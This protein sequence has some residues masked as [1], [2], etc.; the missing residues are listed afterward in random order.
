M[1]CIGMHQFVFVFLC[2]V[3]F[4]DIVC[5]YYYYHYNRF[6]ALW[7]LSGTAR[8]S[9]YKKGKTNLHLLEQEIVSGSGI[10]WTMCTAPH[11]R[12]ITTP[13]FHHS[14]FTGRMPFLLSNKQHCGC[15]MCV[16]VGSNED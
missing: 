14:I 7:I 1:F 3:L 6:T 10:I 12:H 2:F 11:P 15:T 16:T 13:A 5:S 8:V 9:R 4:V